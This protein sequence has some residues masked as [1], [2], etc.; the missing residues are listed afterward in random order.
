MGWNNRGSNILDSHRLWRI[1][2]VRWNADKRLEPLAIPWQSFEPHSSDHHQCCS[3]SNFK[4]IFLFQNQFLVNFTYFEVWAT[5]HGFGW[6]HS[7]QN[8]HHS[9]DFLYRTDFLIFQQRKLFLTTFFDLQ[10]NCS[11]DATQLH[12]IAL[13]FHCRSFPG[14]Q[15]K[16]I[17]CEYH[18]AFQ[19]LHPS[20]VLCPEECSNIS[21]NTQLAAERRTKCWRR[22]F[23][24]LKVQTNIWVKYFDLTRILIHL[25]ASR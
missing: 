19:F 21:S 7:Q 4:I 17:P 15:S 6:L 3:L 1:L 18:F 8:P 25:P 20:I 2:L 14:Y 16:R 22:I 10:L 13:T 23:E 5:T 24:T 9:R 12:P 11:R